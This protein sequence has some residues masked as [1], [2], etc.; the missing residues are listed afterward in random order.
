MRGA[1]S[2]LA[3]GL[4]V[5]LFGCILS[6][7]VE[8]RYA[9]RE[10]AIKDGLVEKGWVPDWMIPPSATDIR[11]ETNLDTNTAL[12]RFSYKNR[13]METAIAGCK[14]ADR[15]EMKVPIGVY[16]PSWG[17]LVSGV[18]AAGLSWDLVVCEDTR[19]RRTVLWSVVVN[20]ARER[21]VAWHD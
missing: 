15:R 3:V 18:I 9:T 8:K 16:V 21:A 11:V 4:T 10:E 20:K 5:S 14:K 19:D 12:L 17:S 13:E 6:D 2:V 1:P 7:R